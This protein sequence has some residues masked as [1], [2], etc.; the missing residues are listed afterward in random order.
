MSPEPT[1]R[2]DWPSA[3]TSG[4]SALREPMAFVRAHAVPLAFFVANILIRLPGIWKQD[5]PPFNFCDE[6]I[7]VGAAGRMTLLKTWLVSDEFKAGGLNIYLP[8]IFLRLGRSLGLFG[9]DF[10]STLRTAIR[11]SRLPTALLL[12]SATV[13]PLYGMARHFGRRTSWLALLLFTCSP[14]VLAHSR[15]HYPDHFVYFFSALFAYCT[16]RFASAPSSQRW[17]AWVAFSVACAAST[18]YFAVLLLVPFVAVYCWLLVGHVRDHGLLPALRKSFVDVAFF[19]C[20]LSGVLVV[21]NLGA[22]IYT[23]RFLADHAYN[24]KNYGGDAPLPLAQAFPNGIAFYA[25]ILFVLSL[26]W[27]GLASMLLGLGAVIRKRHWIGLMLLLI[28][29]VFLILFMGRYHSYLSRNISSALPMVLILAAIGL[30]QVMDLLPSKTYLMVIAAAFVLAEGAGRTLYAFRDDFGTDTRLQA[31]EWLRANVRPPATIGY[32][33]ACHY[34]PPGH[35]LGY[36]LRRLDQT[37]AAQLDYIVSDSWWSPSM[38]PPGAPYPSLLRVLDLRDLHY[39]FF[40]GRNPATL[41]VPA[42]FALLRTIEGPGPDVHI[43]GRE[44]KTRHQTE[45]NRPP[46]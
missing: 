14:L 5:L 22:L 13:F 12:S 45:R 46:G 7:F 16:F 29:P 37:P 32:S 38:R 23:D 36:D 44:P 3:V 31:H 24:M 40:N 19:T 11:L 39:H 43:Y 42:G 35:G 17:L 9:F 25:L 30:D 8:L 10:L 2:R 15:M 1:K 4:G 26:G 33:R 41:P 28:Y 27:A 21:L 34:Q 20:V 6:D 18:K